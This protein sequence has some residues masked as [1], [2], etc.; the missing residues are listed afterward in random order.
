LWA[1]F[2]EIGSNRPIFIGRD[3]IIHYDV[4]Q[5][6]AERR[7][8]YRWYTDEPAKLLKVDYA[9]WRAK[10]NIPVEVTKPGP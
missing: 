7:N 4:S 1:R 10:L 2:Y 5:I 8:G 3:S 9:I 6:E